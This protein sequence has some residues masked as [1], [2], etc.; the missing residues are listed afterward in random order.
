MSVS[1]TKAE[2]RAQIAALREQLRNL[3]RQ[4]AE[5]HSAALELL[6]NGMSRH[7]VSIRLELS[8]ESI[9]QFTSKHRR[10]TGE[11]FPYRRKDGGGNGVLFSQR[12]LDIVA[13]YREIGTLEATGASFGLTSERVRQIVVK[14]ERITGETI[15]RTKPTAGPRIPLSC[16]GCGRIRSVVPSIAANASPWCI[17]CSGFLRGVGKDRVNNIIALRRTL[18][19]WHQTGLQAGYTGTGTWAAARVVYMRLTYDGRWDEIA[20][21]WPKGIPSWLKKWDRSIKTAA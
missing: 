8:Y 5:W 2:L 15:E 14:Y 3:R 20:E 16:P 6:R 21:L 11:A 17:R 7:D 9:L 18:P 4:P 10:D 19:N 12:H 13:A 1:E